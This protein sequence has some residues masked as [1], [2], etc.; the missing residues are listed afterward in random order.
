[1]D[2]L[3]PKSLALVETNRNE[4]VPT[5]SSIRVSQ[6]TNNAP[7]LKLVGESANVP[8]VGTGGQEV[9]TIDAWLS[10]AFD[11]PNGREAQPDQNCLYATTQFL[12]PRQYLD[13]FKVI[14]CLQSIEPVTVALPFLRQFP[15]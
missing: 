9:R 8:E 13:C 4:N 11:E 3:V 14:W 12:S 1:M 7:A 2:V 10:V 5:P 6:L 15:T